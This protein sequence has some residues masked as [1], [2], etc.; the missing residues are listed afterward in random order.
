MKGDEGRHSLPDP[1]YTREGPHPL[2][3]KNRVKDRLV[4][5]PLEDSKKNLSFNNEGVS[6]LLMQGDHTQSRGRPKIQ[7]TEEDEIARQG[8][9]GILCDHNEKKTGPPEKE[10]EGI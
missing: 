5:R 8:K 7:T 9:K 6:G 10:R 3:Q 2:K 1:S 4:V